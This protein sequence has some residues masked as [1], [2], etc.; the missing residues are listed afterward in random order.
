MSMKVAPPIPEPSI[1]IRVSEAARLMGVSDS[2]VWA[3]GS[4]K[5]PRRLEGFPRIFPL[6]RGASGM[7]RKHLEEFLAA[8]WIKAAEEDAPSTFAE[9][10]SIKKQLQRDLNGH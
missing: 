7:F 4:S 1:I 3:W 9:Q 10:R 8:Q 5:S 6:G 2:T